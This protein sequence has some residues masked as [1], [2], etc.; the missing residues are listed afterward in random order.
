MEEREANVLYNAIERFGPGWKVAAID[1]ACLRPDGRPD[2]AKCTQDSGVKKQATLTW[3]AAGPEELKEFESK[4]GGGETACSNASQTPTYFLPWP[5]PRAT[6]SY[7]FP[8]RALSDFG[9]LGRFNDALQTRLREA[10]FYDF[11]YFLVPGGFA[12]ATPIERIDPEGYPAAGSSRWKGGNTPV[13]PTSFSDWVRKVLYDE[14]G[15]F[16]VFVFIVTT[17]SSPN[18]D[19]S[20]T[21]EEA[22]NW[23]ADGCRGL[24]AKMLT[25]K[26]SSDQ[27]F[28]ALAYVFSSS[29]GKSSEQLSNF[30]ASISQQFANT[31]IKF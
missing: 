12:L 24:P 20:A 8:Q 11:S 1:P 13:G 25:T 29:K 17:D 31:G 27:I 26:I 28:Y 19:K 16:R 2:L 4:F 6:S 30:G 21:F 9:T 10:G 22:R 3:P 18:A 14:E 5:P 15:Y 7:S 23:A